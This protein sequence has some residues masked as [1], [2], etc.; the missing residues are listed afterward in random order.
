MKLTHEQITEIQNNLIHQYRTAGL[1]ERLYNVG[2]FDGI[3][4]MLGLLGYEVKAQ[5]TNDLSLKIY[6]VESEE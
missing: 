6:V 5:L 1:S 2:V 4:F 3:K